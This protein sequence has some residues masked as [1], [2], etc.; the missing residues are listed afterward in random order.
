MEYIKNNGIKENL[1]RYG[2]YVYWLQ[3]QL[4]ESIPIVVRWSKNVNQPSIEVL[5]KLLNTRC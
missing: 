3:E 1:R 5:S 2:E 4:H